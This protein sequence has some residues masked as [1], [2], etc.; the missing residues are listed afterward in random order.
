KLPEAL[1]EDPLS[2]LHLPG[3]LQ[4]I[5]PKL[6]EMLRNRA[7]E[8]DKDVLPMMTRAGSQIVSGLGN[9][10]SLV[11]VPILA[12]FFLKDGAKMH[13]EFI[14]LFTPATRGIVNDILEDLHH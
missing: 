7:S 8:L 11:L 12:F 6:S 9:V 10:L 13:R 2:N 3:W 5:Q 1:K 4:P 14:I